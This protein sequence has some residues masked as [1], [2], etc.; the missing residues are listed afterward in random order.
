MKCKK[1]IIFFI[2][3]CIINICF[4]TPVNAMDDIIQSG[5]NFL[6]KGDSVEQTINTVALHKTSDF[7]YNLFLIVAI[8]VAVIVGTVLGIKFIT[9]SVEGQAK[10]KEAIIPYIVGCVVIFSAFTIWSFV[11]NVGQN[12]EKEDTSTFSVNN[13]NPANLVD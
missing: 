10:V 3:I 6:S 5:K 13:V 1:V 4:V 2:I 9:S 11:V 12:L 8:I 7:I